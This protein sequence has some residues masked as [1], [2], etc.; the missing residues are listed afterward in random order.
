MNVDMLRYADD[1]AIAA[2]EKVDLEIVSTQ[3]KEKIDC[4][5]W[6]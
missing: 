5:E 6:R 2:E 3:W 1:V 4:I